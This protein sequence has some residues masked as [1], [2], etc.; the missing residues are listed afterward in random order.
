M[1]LVRLIYGVAAMSI[2]FAVFSFLQEREEE[3]ERKASRISTERFFD[4]LQNTHLSTQQKVEIRKFWRNA[5]RKHAGNSHD[6]PIGDIER[7]AHD[8]GQ[9]FPDIFPTEMVVK[10]ARSA[11]KLR[12][13]DFAQ[14]TSSIFLL[15][16]KRF[17]AI[18]KDTKG[19]V[20]LVV[21]RTVRRYLERALDVV[22][23]R[24]KHALKDEHMPKYLQVSDKISMIR[25]RLMLCVT[26]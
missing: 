7:L 5:I 2:S 9:V 17:H 22:A 20:K 19:E 3:E 25:L 26:R 1:R 24:L 15:T 8:Y 18:A 6:L 11:V 14:S 23:D 12:R 13:K 16:G 4:Y 10:A 21:H